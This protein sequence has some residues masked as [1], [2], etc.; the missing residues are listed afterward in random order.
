LIRKIIVL[1]FLA[2]WLT[3]QPAP[4]MEA[5]AQDWGPALFNNKVIHDFGTVARGALAEHRFKL[6]N[7]YREDIEINSVTAACGCTKLSSTKKL[8]KMYETAEIVA[9][10]DTRRFIGFKEA[11]I[12]VSVAFRPADPGRSPVPAEVQLKLRSFIRGDVVFE[13]GVV[14]F[15]SVA[16]GQNVQKQ[17]AVTYAGRPNWQILDAVS[18]SPHVQVSFKQTGR[19]IDPALNATKVTYDLA[20]T[21]KDTA[22]AGYL[23]ERITLKT[24]D[25]KQEN[26]R[27]PLAVQ[28]LV[29]P[30]LTANP[31]MLML[32]DLKPGQSVSKNVVIRGD[33]PFRVSGVSGPGPDGQFRFTHAT[34]AKPVHLLTVHFTAGNKPGKV[35][36][37]IR[38]STDL[39]GASV[40]VDV[41]GKILPG[42]SPAGDR[43]K[44]DGKRGA[45]K[46]G[47]TKPDA[48]KPDAARPDAARPP[49]NVLRT[50]PLKEV[51]PGGDKTPSATK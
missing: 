22:P 11:T 7:V 25:E 26:A 44:T 13:P 43:P 47:E 23:Q 51:E 48:A 2:L 33:K 37:K 27:V 49:G 5:P 9:E 29:V 40:D 42:D 16:P 34:D 19:N 35:T 18:S 12:R 39:G 21:L 28:G 17:V 24:N 8:V 46:T 30:S 45:A 4:A 36:G 14:Q 20:V 41:D 32:G 31:A 1:P 38:I 50:G 10:L 6:E 15:D 3:A